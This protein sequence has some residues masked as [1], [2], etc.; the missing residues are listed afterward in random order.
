MSKKRRKISQQAKDFQ[1]QMEKLYYEDLGKYTWWDTFVTVLERYD[2]NGESAISM[3]YDLRLSFRKFLRKQF[4]K[5]KKSCSRW[6]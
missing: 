4:N 6:K 2:L 5:N 3:W 1:S